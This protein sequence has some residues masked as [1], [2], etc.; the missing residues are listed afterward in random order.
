MMTL[1]QVTVVLTWLAVQPTFSNDVL[2]SRKT[3]KLYFVRVLNITIADSIYTK[4][5]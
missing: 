3:S 2:Y 5:S 4:F 1:V